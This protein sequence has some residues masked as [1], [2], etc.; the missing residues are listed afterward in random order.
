MWSKASGIYGSLAWSAAVKLITQGLVLW[1][2]HPTLHVR[3]CN[4]PSSTM[5]G[6]WLQITF[7]GG[8]QWSELQK[9]ATYKHSECNRCKGV[10]DAKCK[11][12]LHGPTGWVQG[13]GNIPLVW[14]HHRWPSRELDNAPAVVLFVRNRGLGFRGACCYLVVLYL[15]ALSP[16]LSCLVVQL[17][18]V[19]LCLVLLCL[20]QLHLVLLFPVL[21]HHGTA[22][23]TAGLPIHCH[24]GSCGFWK[25]VKTVQ[26]ARVPTMP[27]QLCNTTV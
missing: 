26:P 2:A 4:L 3:Q 13:P 22:H 20:V 10:P 7:N 8:S 19:L 15:V 5:T 27:L 25:Q 16:V 1:H 14:Q 12:H 9:P 23:H 17:Y 24:R 18:L 21:L 11:L 6:C